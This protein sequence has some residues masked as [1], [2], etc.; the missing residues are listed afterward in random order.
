M[1]VIRTDA[2][3]HVRDLKSSD[4][5]DIYL[6]GGGAFAGSLLRAGLIDRLVLKLNPVAIGAGVPLFG[7]NERPFDATARFKLVATH[8]YES[9][10]ALLT[11]DAA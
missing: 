11:Y 9:G 3:A 8:A 6:C 7:A 4:G 10:V 2:A 1:N 5:G